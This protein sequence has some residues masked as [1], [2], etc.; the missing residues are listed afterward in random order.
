MTNDEIADFVEGL[1]A[2]H[3]LADAVLSK[4]DREVLHLAARRLREHQK[5]MALL[6]AKA[7][8]LGPKHRGS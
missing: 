2:L 6:Q 8:H 1:V 3:G 7:A 5:L 4:Q